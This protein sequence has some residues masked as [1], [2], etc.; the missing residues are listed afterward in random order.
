MKK[1]KIYF[2]GKV[3]LLLITL[4]F[5]A[6]TYFAF[7]M[8]EAGMPPVLFDDLYAKGAKK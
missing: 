1:K 6:F 8:P 2:V 3:G 7:L 5:I 4:F